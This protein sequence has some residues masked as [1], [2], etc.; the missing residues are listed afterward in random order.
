MKKF[1]AVL[2]TIS[3]VLFAVAVSSGGYMAV[4]RHNIAKYCSEMALDKALKIVPTNNH[5]EGYQATDT[6]AEYNLLYNSCIRTH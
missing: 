5:T 1:W 4:H 6:E 2:A 3:V